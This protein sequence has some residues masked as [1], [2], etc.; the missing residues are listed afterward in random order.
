MDVPCFIDTEVVE[1][2]VTEFVKIPQDAIDFLSSFK[3][4]KK[5]GDIWTS[6]NL[7]L[8]SG[9]GKVEGLCLRIR[10]DLCKRDAGILQVLAPLLKNPIYEDYSQSVKSTIRSPINIAARLGYTNIVY[11]LAPVVNNFN[12][13]TF[14]GYT[15]LHYAVVWGNLD[16]VKFLMPLT[17]DVYVVKCYG[18]TAIQIAQRMNGQKWHEIVKFLESYRKIQI[19]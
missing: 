17:T 18:L 12:V 19:V 15:P 13:T 3:K 1:K 10:K 4:S 8:H 16:I 11:V 6:F 5:H 2:F 14:G 7:S 9:E